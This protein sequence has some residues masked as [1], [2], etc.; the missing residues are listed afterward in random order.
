M[1]NFILFFTLAVFST[2]SSGTVENERNNNTE[3]YY[4][5][6][7][8]LV[9]FCVYK[10]NELNCCQAETYEEAKFCAESM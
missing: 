9:S 8:G 7:D 5:S 2:V 4:F 1:K 10:N 3:S 6:E